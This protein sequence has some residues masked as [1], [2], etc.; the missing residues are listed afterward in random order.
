VPLALGLF[1]VMII[2]LA[3]VKRFWGAKEIKTKTRG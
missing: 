2:C 3:G 1:A